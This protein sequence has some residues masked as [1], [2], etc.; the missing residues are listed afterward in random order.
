M[1]IPSSLSPVSR[2]S[3][4]LLPGRIRGGS[5]LSLSIAPNQPSLLIPN[6]CRSAA[7]SRAWLCF[8]ILHSLELLGRLDHLTE[9]TVN[10]CIDFLSRCQDPSGGFC[11]GRSPT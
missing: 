5:P 2:L 7:D 4:D 10:S 8:W 11:G 3:L 6:R 9:K 1:T